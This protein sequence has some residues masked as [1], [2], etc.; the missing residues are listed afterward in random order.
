MSKDD[1]KLSK[2]Y[3]LNPTMCK[4]FFCGEVKHLALMGHIGDYRKNEDIE[5]PHECI[6]DYEPCDKCIENMSIGVTL[7]EVTT[8]QP[9]DNRPPLK[10]QGGIEVYPLGRWCVLR[11]EACQTMF[12]NPDL[13][14]GDKMFVDSE[15]MTDILSNAQE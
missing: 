2:K 10:A 15:V 13:E 8:E 14:A 1:I 11:A 7:I 3:G 5:A 4:C 6:M 12:N 9:T